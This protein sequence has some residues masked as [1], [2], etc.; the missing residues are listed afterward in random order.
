MQGVY[1]Q[2]YGYIGLPSKLSKEGPI[3]IKN[4]L[5]FLDLILNATTQNIG[6]G[7]KF[8]CLDTSE[9]TDLSFLKDFEFDEENPGVS[10]TIEKLHSILKKN[11]FRICFLIPKDYFLASQLD[12]VGD[13][14]SIYLERISMI[15]DLLGQRGRSIIVRI[16]SAY[17]NR[18]ST[19]ATFNERLLDLSESCSKKIIVVNDEKPSLFS[20]TDLISG[21][22]YISGIPVCFRFLNH[23]FNDGGL[24]VREAFFLSCST[25]KFGS[26]PIIIHAEPS[27]VDDSGTPSSPKPASFIER[28]IPTFGL[29]PDVLIDSPEKELACIKYMAEKNKLKPIVINKKNDK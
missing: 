27:E 24:S 14:T 6:Y 22:Y 8:L 1:Y 23:F 21:C 26:N 13:E 4:E 28:R 19:L 2:R 7:I 15:L 29:F 18:K 12:G 16:G 20:V 3:R 10:R 25:W 9:F 11:D 5:D 17:G